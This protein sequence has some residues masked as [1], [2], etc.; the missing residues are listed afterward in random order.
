MKEIVRARGHPNVRARHKTTLEITRDRDLTPRGDCIIGVDADKSLSDLSL[1][2]RDWLLRGNPVKIEIVLPD[3]G[4]KDDLIAFGSRGLTFKHE[5]D[6][7]VRKSD[8]VCDRTLAIRSNKS[9]RDI[10]REIVNLLRDSKTE[11]LF[12]ITA[13]PFSASR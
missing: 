3:Y 10:D 1:E 12:V 7:V 8:F 5:R 11:L 2:I 9:A 6:I 13:K 4:L